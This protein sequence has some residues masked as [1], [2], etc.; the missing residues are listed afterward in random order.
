MPGSATRI[1]M[2]GFKPRAQSERESRPHI[3]APRGAPES[4][5]GTGKIACDGGFDH[6]ENFALQMRA[7]E[8]IAPVAGMPAIE[9][10]VDGERGD[11]EFFDRA[12]KPFRVG[13][14]IRRV[15]RAYLFPNLAPHNDGGGMKRPVV[16]ADQV[17]N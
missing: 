5:E 8:A 10:A 7:A 3:C 11:G 4:P 1:G 6:F 9:D 16:V 2:T 14:L 13:E 17:W 12:E 15:E